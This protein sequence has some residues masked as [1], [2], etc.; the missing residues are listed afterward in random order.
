L[1]FV[2][3]CFTP[4]MWTPIFFS[5]HIWRSGQSVLAGLLSRCPPSHPSSTWSFFFAPLISSRW[6]YWRR[7]KYQCSVN[8]GSPWPSLE[9]KHC[10]MYY[11]G[12]WFSFRLRFLFLCLCIMTKFCIF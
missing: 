6:P 11:V 12:T 7:W 9:G 3:L 10:K 5:G 1:K 8:A 4:F 2:P